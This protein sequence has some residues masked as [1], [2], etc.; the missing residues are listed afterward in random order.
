M[1]MAVGGFNSPQGS[2]P[3]APFV[4]HVLFWLNDKGNRELYGR[5]VAALK[6]LRRVETTR[7]TTCIIRCTPGSWRISAPPRASWQTL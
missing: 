3:D 7:S 4:H 2:A 5:L 1:M 6:Q